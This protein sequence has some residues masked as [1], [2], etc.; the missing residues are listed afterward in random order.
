[1]H[2]HK[3]MNPWKRQG[4]IKRAFIHFLFI[5]FELD[6]IILLL[7]HLISSLKC[8]INSKIGRTIN[9]VA[10]SSNIFPKGIT[11]LLTYQYTLWGSRYMKSFCLAFYFFRIIYIC[12]YFLYRPNHRATIYKNYRPLSVIMSSFLIQ[13]YIWPREFIVFLL[14]STI[15]TCKFVSHYFWAIKEWIKRQYLHG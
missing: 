9:T 13:R 2:C 10:L 15:I 3:T 1:M 14:C 4:S 5:F 6:L 8:V 12:V 7:Y 11:F